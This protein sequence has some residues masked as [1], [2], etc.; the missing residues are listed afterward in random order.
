M[1]IYVPNVLCQLVT[2]MGKKSHGAFRKYVLYEDMNSSFD[3]NTLRANNVPF[4][5]TLLLN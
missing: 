1:K 5:T 2:T 4:M 3:M